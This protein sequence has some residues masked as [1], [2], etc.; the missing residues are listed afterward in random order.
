MVP[1]GQIAYLALRT[2]DLDEAVDL[3]SRRMDAEV[4]SMYDRRETYALVRISPF[5]RE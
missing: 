3:L 2:D 4:V 5:F 1:V